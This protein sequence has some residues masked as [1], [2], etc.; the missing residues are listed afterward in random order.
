MVEL[1]CNVKNELGRLTTLKI[2]HVDQN[3]DTSTGSRNVYIPK[4][5]DGNALQKFRC[6]QQNI[7]DEHKND[8]EPKKHSLWFVA[9][10]NNALQKK[11]D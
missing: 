3:I 4:A 6:G 2:G 11:R 8:N 5:L 7:A 1:D 10:L 9:I